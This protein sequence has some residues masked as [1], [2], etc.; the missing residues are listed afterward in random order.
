MTTCE[1]VLSRSEVIISCHFCLLTRWLLNT[2]R[3]RLYVQVL[4]SLPVSLTMTMTVCTG[5]D[6]STCV[7]DNDDDCMYRCR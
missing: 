7:I 2:E 1:N 3:W 6:E 4:M 5:A